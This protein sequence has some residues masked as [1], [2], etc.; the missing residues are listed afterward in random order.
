M[1]MDNLAQELMEI[2]RELEEVEQV[3]QQQHQNEE[4]MISQMKEEK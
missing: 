2:Q 4:N 1:I 3:I